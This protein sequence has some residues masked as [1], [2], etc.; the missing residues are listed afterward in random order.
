[1]PIARK[2][3]EKSLHTPPISPVSTIQ[4]ELT[5]PLDKTERSDA[6]TEEETTPSW[7]VSGQIKWTVACQAFVMFIVSIDSTILTTTL[8][9]SENNGRYSV[10]LLMIF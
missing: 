9:V 3:S 1:M 5:L 6:S 10:S 4:S 8:P 2:L 7:A